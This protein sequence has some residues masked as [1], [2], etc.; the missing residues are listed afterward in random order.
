MAFISK[1]SIQLGETGLLLGVLP[2][3]IAGSLCVDIYVCPECNE[4]E[5]FAAEEERENDLPKK[6]CPKCKQV[7]DFDYP[8]YPNCKHEYF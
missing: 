5:L 6:T 3:L 1:E 4:L 8:R 7:H 2:N